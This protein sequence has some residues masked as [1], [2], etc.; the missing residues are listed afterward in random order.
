MRAMLLSLVVVL[1]ATICAGCG[2][3]KDKGGSSAISQH[4]IS[5]TLPQVESKSDADSD[6][7]KYGSEPDNESEVFGR[8]AGAVDSRAVR[9]LLKR[10]YAAAAAGDGAEGCRLLYVPIAESVAEDLGASTGPAGLRGNSCAAVLS[11]LF[12]RSHGHW[13]AD[14]ATLRVAAVRVQGNRGVARLS[15]HG[16]RTARYV[17]AHRE[18][19]GWKLALL[20]DVGYPVG[21]E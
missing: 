17:L 2:T 16:N 3:G 19:G 7:D 14:S 21:V 18:R 8:P 10:Y 4:V 11:K 15:F 6:S 9:R 13:S 20:Q 1:S 5:A 12:K